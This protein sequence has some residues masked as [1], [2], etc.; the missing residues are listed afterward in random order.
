MSAESTTQSRVGWGAAIAATLLLF[1]VSMDAFMMPLATSAIVE[2]L[3]TDTGMMQVAI[4]LVSL[5]AAPLYI[6]GGK[7]GDIN[8]KKR[9]FMA[10]IVLMGIGHVIAAL[11]PSIIVL[12]GGWS[13]IRALGLVLGVPA[14]VGLLIASYPDEGQRGQAF[15]IYGVG[16][17]TAALVGPL[18][19]GIAAEHLS[20]RVPFALLGVLMAINFFLTSSVMNETEKIDGAT[21]DWAGTIMMFLGIAPLIL[22][23]MLGGQYGWW[24]T[25]RP[26]N[27]GDTTIE[28]L[29]LS[30]APLLMG[31]GVVMMTI[32]LSRL[33]AMEERGGQPLFSLSLFDNR[34]FASVWGMALFGFVPMGALPFIIPV[35]T[36]QALDFGSLD[37]GMVM[38][39]FSIGSIIFGFASGSLIQQ[40]QART[41]MQ[42][43]LAVIVIGLLWL[44]A[45]TDVNMTLETFFLPMFVVG[46]GIGVFTSQVPN[47]QLATLEPELQGEASG[48]SEAGKELPVGL[49]TAVIGSIMFSMAM[50]SFVDNV[51]RSNNISLTFEERRQI[52]VQI[53]DE[54]LPKEAIDVI[55]QT[56]DVEQLGQQAYVEGFQM[57]IG[58]LVAVAFLSLLV[59]SFIPKVDADDHSTQ[60][61]ADVASKQV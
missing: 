4:A 60:L 8:G 6:A 51:A 52:I 30:P 5:V 47:I 38:I 57:A 15:A 46:A 39:A 17:V 2:E 40:M 29:G 43:S 10:G 36:Q 54:A 49:G 27:I 42:I 23:S 21:I 25:R 1:A 18:L 11:A 19:M 33:H 13:V 53:E 58:M 45:V 7:L 12:I 41:L 32:L 20:W 9:I 14:S 48:F 3:E 50:G 61:V 34:T 28:F 59:G 16:G 26:F 37:S 56:P 22:G 31:F 44:V 24:L 55:E 35:F